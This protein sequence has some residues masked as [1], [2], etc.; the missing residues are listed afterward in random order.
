MQIDFAKLLET[1]FVSF[2]ACAV[3]VVT[4]V[5]ANGAT[6]NLYWPSDYGIFLIDMYNAARLDQA[7]GISSRFGWSH[8][9]PMNYYALLPFYALS[10][11]GVQSLNLGTFVLNAACLGWSTW[12]IAKLSCRGLA[13]LYVTGAIAFLSVV[14]PV[15]SMWDVLL[16]LSTVCPWL[17]VFVLANAVSVRGLRWTPALAFASC[18]VTQAHVAFWLPTAALITVSLMISVYRYGISRNDSVHVIFAATLGSVF[19][20]PPILQWDNLAKIFDFFLN[21]A[22]THSLQDALGAFAGMLGWSLT[23][24]PQTFNVARPFDY[25]FGGALFATGIFSLIHSLINGNRFATTISALS[26]LTASVMALSLTKYNGPILPHSIIFAMTL[27]PMLLFCAVAAFAPDLK[28][29]QVSMGSVAIVGIAIVVWSPASR[30][31]TAAGQPNQQVKELTEATLKVIKMND[32]IYT[33][34]LNR[35]EWPIPVG[36]LAQLYRAGVSFKIDPFWSIIFGH[37]VPNSTL[38]PKLL[39]NSDKPSGIVVSP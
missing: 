6:S 16:P 9:G 26:I 35:A 23:N 10:S 17:L 3:A 39:F 5:L 1:I 33:I 11:G 27:S 31:I 21:S 7:V 13:I 28:T 24:N 19:W 22:E 18:F 36:V 30:A 20:L 38:P 37:R 2:L 12:T 8:P 15:H 14:L 34:D 25:V 29:L 32:A 4:A